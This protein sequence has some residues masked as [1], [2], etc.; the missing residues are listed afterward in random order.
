[1]KLV[2][3]SRARAL[4]A[5][6]LAML[7]VVLAAPDNLDASATYLVYHGSR[8]RPVIALTFD[9]G[10]SASSTQRIFEI[11][12]R[13]HVAATFFPYARAVQSAPSLW[14][15]IALAGYPIANH[16][17][18]HADL[19][20]LSPSS[21]RWEIAT[22]R[23]VVEKITGRPMLR[24]YRPPYG[25][26]NATVQREAAAAGFGTTVMWDLSSA[27]TARHSGWSSIQR[28]ALTGSNGSI[29]L[30]HCG[31]AVTPAILDAVI[32]GYQARGFRFVTVA[33]LLGPKMAPWPGVSPSP[34]PTP[35]ASPTSTTSP[36]PS[37]TPCP[38]EGPCPAP[39]AVSPTPAPPPWESPAPSPSPSPGPADSP[40][41]GRFLIDVYPG[42]GGGAQD[43]GEQ[44]FATIVSR[45]LMMVPSYA[46]VALADAIV[47]GISGLS[48]TDDEAPTS[49]PTP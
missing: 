35:T 8:A 11:L 5:G 17:T 20:H 2:G 10:W 25:A 42:P 26:Y 3:R 32:S 9:D 7:L 48:C 37:S 33:E 1:M 34:S 46:A 16:T 44:A 15:R 47:R 23:Q 13:R 14:R 4:A 19:T 22:A 38:P 45:D 40:M 29:V 36:T 39:P 12:Q 49:P 43:A 28:R 41:P 30:M 31:P 18:T 24:V 27:D 6:V 21:I